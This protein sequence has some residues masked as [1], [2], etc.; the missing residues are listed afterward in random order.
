MRTSELR[1]AS[2]VYVPGGLAN[3]NGVIN[4]GI[5]ISQFNIFIISLQMTK[6]INYA[7]LGA[8][9]VTF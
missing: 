6:I 9:E 5:L 7:F 8:N 3:E 2:D 4:L 1:R